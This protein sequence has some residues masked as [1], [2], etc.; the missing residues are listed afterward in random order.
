MDGTEMMGRARWGS[1]RRVVGGCAR[2]NVP[3]AGRD[4]VLGGY[5]VV[6]V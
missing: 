4:A 1:R 6:C 2:Y 5:R 3:E